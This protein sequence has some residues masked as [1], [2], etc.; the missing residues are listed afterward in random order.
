MIDGDDFV[1]ILS[2]EV[3]NSK[4]PSFR[5]LNLEIPERTFLLFILNII[6]R[7]I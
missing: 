2:N 7:A 4:F 5:I 6:K 1:I 3:N